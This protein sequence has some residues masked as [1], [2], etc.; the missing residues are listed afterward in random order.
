MPLK[1]IYFISIQSNAAYEPIYLLNALKKR[2]PGLFF[3]GYN[4]FVD[5]YSALS[6]GINTV[7]LPVYLAVSIN[8]RVYLKSTPSDIWLEPVVCCLEL[9]AA[10][11]GK[12]LI[13]VAKFSSIRH[14]Q[15]YQCSLGKSIWKVSN[16]QQPWC[17]IYT[18]IPAASRWLQTSM[19]S[20]SLDALFA[21][22]IQLEK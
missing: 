10:Y 4:D 2:H 18:T 7:K 12:Q 9:L 17:E 6:N 3:T 13:G 19:L 8:L 15:G 22:F 21:G 14:L 5:I 1:I 11:V 16:H 20:E